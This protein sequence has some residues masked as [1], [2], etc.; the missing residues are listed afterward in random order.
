[1]DVNAVV[2]IIRKLAMLAPFL[3]AFSAGWKYL[4]VVRNTMNEGVIP[5]MNALL[6]FFIALGGGQAAA[7]VV[8]MLFPSVAHAGILGDVKH[9]LDPAI[10]AFISVAFSL[11]LAKVHDKFIKPLTPPS[12]YRERM[13]TP[14]S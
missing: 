7:P 2:E 4:P 8:G 10:G 9:A 13:G 11:F 1:M 5:I 12:P 6:T 14:V 3:M